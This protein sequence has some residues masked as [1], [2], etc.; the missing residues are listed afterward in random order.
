MSKREDAMGAE[1]ARRAADAA[2]AE[3]LR[4]KKIQCFDS[5]RLISGASDELLRHSGYKTRDEGVLGVFRRV[6]DQIDA[7][8]REHFKKWGD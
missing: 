6:M 4:Q 1:E 7:G 5:Q 2:H 3:W 8:N